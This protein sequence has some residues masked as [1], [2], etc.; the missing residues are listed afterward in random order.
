VCG[1]GG[2][3]RHVSVAGSYAAPISMQN[4]L[5]GAHRLET[6]SISVPSH[7]ACA[8]APGRM[9][10]GAAGNMCQD[11]GVTDGGVVE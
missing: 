3:D 10:I 2:S 5:S 6:I 7:T 11:A 1:I 8:D 4:R 9:A